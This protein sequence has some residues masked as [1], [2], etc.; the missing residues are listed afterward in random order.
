MREIGPDTMTDQRKNMRA[1]VTLAVLVTLGLVG[2]PGFGQGQQRPASW[3]SFEEGNAL[4][5]QREFGKALEQYK[6]AIASAGTFPEAEMAIGD[7]YREE[8][9][10]DLARKQ[11]EK[12]YNMRSSFYIPDSKYD[13]LYKLTKTLKTRISSS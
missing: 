7:V 8:G 1:T 3:L 9:E 2:F 12:A 4:V 5:S 13:V 10:L 6:N 11:Y